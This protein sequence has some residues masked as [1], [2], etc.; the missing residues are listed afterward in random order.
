VVLLLHGGKPR[1][2]G[3][4][5]A[6]SASVWRM[7]SLAAAI[8]PR[9]ERSGVACWLLRYSARGWNGG[10]PVA[11]ARWAL[12]EV[13]AAHPGVPVVLLG[14][15]MGGRTGARVADH[16]AVAGLVALAPWFE[17]TDP[18]APLAGKRLAAAHGT[19]D[20][21]TSA[22]AT[23][24]FVQRAAAVAERAEFV[25]MGWTGHYLLHDARRWFTTAERL[26]REIADL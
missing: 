3:P 4:V 24:Q 8:G 20:R 16:P 12:D 1:D 11:D 5:P 15:S 14:H 18:V 2:P 26:V 13:R 22:R 17:A 21:I 19:R 6:R 10:A 9:L 23:R 7:R 25:D